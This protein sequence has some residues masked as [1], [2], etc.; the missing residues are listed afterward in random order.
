MHVLEAQPED[1]IEG[2]E[3][4]YFSKLFDIRAAL[5]GKA[6]SPTVDSRLRPTISDE[7]EAERSCS[8]CPLV[9]MNSVSE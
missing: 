5:T 4:T 2:A 6:Q 3:V 8:P 9:G 1:T 7:D